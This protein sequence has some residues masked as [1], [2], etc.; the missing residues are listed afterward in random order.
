MFDGKTMYEIY[1]KAGGDASGF[2]AIARY[3]KDT[4]PV[5]GRATSGYLYEG[6]SPFSYIE[7][8]PI[9]AVVSDGSPLLQWLPSRFINYRFENV[10]HLEWIGP[11]DFDGSQTYAEWLNGLTIPECGYG[12]ATDW[13][14]F[15]Y[16]MSGGSFSWS[17]K[18]MKPYL[19]DNTKYYE[20]SPVYRMRGAEQGMPLTSDR[21]WA[22]ARL[23]FAMVTH[24][25]YVL[26]FGDRQNSDME[27]DG[28]L[29]ILQ[30]GYV[31]AR[32]IGSGIPHWADPLYSNGVG[33]ST[34]AALLDAIRRNVRRVRN[35]AMARN[36]DI[37]FGDMAIV[38]NPTMW[39]NLAESIASGAMYKFVNNFNFSGQMSFKDFKDEYRATRTGG[40][41]YGT[42]DIDASPVPVLV[43]GSFGRNITIDPGGTPTPAVLG[44]V[45]ILT[46]R[47]N[48]MVALEQQYVDW[49]KMDYPTN[50]LENIVQMPQG[51]VRAG[52]VTEAN[53]CYYYYAQMA[54][55]IVSYMQ[56]FQSVIQNAAIPTLDT[57]ENESGYFF[58]QDFYAYNGQRGGAGSALLSPV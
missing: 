31:Q 15:E 55:R 35:R 13:S 29:K 26:P 37:S 42:I 17:T 53:A 1:T 11:E 2:D 10:K 20:S 43:D 46:R 25:S 9:S 5:G 22:L 7:G 58:S 3:I 48:G 40:L 47:V 54:G 39:N 21:E 12:P 19:D 41:G 34:P 27:W 38:M 8:D 45:L 28:L 16:Q 32:R 52:W 23:F 18:M 51:H 14:G 49:T 30:P 24:M 56:Q 57:N 4:M 50:G 6:N 44:D 36:W 33:V